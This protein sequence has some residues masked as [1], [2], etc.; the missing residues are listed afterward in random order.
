MKDR[1]IVKAG[2]W[3]VVGK[4]GTHAVVCTVFSNEELKDEIEVVF[5]D[6]RDRAIN[7]HIRW[8]NEYWEFV[9]DLGGYADKY[10]RLR[11]YVR[12]LRSG[13]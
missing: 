3:V 12:I 6:S 8:N 2:D 5:I 10:D 11:K 4:N 7:R 9:G 1:P 13:R